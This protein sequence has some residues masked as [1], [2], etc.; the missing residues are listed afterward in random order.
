VVATD[1]ATLRLRYVKGYIDRYGKARHYFR[2]PGCK[3]V[4]LPGLPGSTE[5]MAAYQAALGT[6]P[7]VSREH[8]PGSIAAPIVDYLRSPAFSNLKLSSQRVYR[9]VLDRFG[10]MHGDRM[11]H[12]MP[13]SAAAA[14]IHQ[15]GAERPAMANITRSI[16]RKLLSH[17]VR[18]GQRNDNPVMEIDNYKVGTRHTWTEGELAAFERRWPLGTRERLAYALLL[19][20]G[21][22]GGDVVKCDGRT[23]LKGPLP[24]CNRKPE[25]RSR[26][27]FIR[28]SPPH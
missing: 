18:L 25:P 19:Y 1:M 15:I 10:T 4:P 8:K 7:P 28:I 16:L 11:V 27:R 13:R 6:P 20:T 26:S 21:Q 22:R 17:A 24:S 23:S 3:A 14:Y 5:F 2:K 9:L 12:D